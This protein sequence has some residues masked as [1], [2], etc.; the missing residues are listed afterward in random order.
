[1]HR[2]SPPLEPRLRAK[3]TAYTRI[4]SIDIGG[5]SIK[6][7]IQGG[8]Q[9]RKAP[10][11]PEFTPQHMLRSVR[12][13]SRGWDYDAVSI[14]FPGLVGDLGP[15]AETKSLGHGWVGFDYEQAFGR[16][17]RWANDAAMQALGS[18]EEGRMLFLGLGTGLGSALVVGRQIV[19]LELG[20][21]LVGER[22]LGE[23]LGRRGMKEAGKRR[24]RRRLLHILP[25]L[26]KALK[27]DHVVLG[28]GN[29]K[30][31]QTLPVGVRI[32]NN[33]TAFRGGVR[34]WDP[35]RTSQGK[36]YWSFL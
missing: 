11:G 36:P 33:L 2:A 16:P 24:W 32:G 19:T 26:Q 13:L 30:H 29:A 6:A 4:L 25:P 14:G 15:K 8:A 27:A 1:M 17:V 31:V 5:H 12:E 7:L 20:E 28:G 22:T 21:L 35:D 18:Y 3:K 34:M 9:P 23:L 10:S